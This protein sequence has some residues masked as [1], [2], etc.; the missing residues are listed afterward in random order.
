MLACHTTSTLLSSVLSSEL[1]S[2]D[3]DGRLSDKD[4]VPMNV[5]TRSHS[6]LPRR[7]KWQEPVYVGNSEPKK[8][9]E[10]AFPDD[11]GTL[12]V[13]EP[14]NKATKYIAAPQEAHSVGEL[15]RHQARVYQI[16]IKPP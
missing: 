3:E 13:Q 12:Q 16:A 6:T 5:T 10:V 11:I 15:D 2:S 7:S 4:D 9:D 8:L 1:D 14:K